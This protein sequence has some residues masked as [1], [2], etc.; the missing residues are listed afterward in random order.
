MSQPPL[1]PAQR[2]WRIFAALLILGALAFVAWQPKVTVIP[3]IPATTCLFHEITGLPCA[4]CGGTRSARAI[5]HGDFSRALHLNA[6]AFPAVALLVLSA[7]ILGGEALRGRAFANWKALAKR[8]K[9]LFPVSLALVFIWWIPQ[10]IGALNGSKSE[11]INL[12]NPIARTL[13]E[14]F[15]SPKP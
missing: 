7:T 9:I 4:L 14:R 1:F 5:L 2:F 10:L 11:L 12:R 15:E 13:S 3:R 6:I 8:Y